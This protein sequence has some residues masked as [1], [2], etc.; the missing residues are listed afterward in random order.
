MPHD[1]NNYRIICLV[2]YSSLETRLRNPEKYLWN[3]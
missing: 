1:L 3:Y 2:I